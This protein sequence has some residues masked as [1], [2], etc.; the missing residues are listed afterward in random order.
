MST[1]E[2]FD[3]YIRQ[4]DEK[5]Y[6]DAISETTEAFSRL[7]LKPFDWVSF[8]QCLMYGDVQS[9]KTSHVLGIIGHAFDEGFR[10]AL[11]LTSDNTRLVDQTFD[12]VLGAFP[13][14]SVCSGNDERRFRS[15][16]KHHKNDQPVIVVLN[17]NKQVLKKWKQVFDSTSAIHGKPLLIVDDEADA[18]SLNAKVNKG[19]VSAINQS[20]GEIRGFAPSCIYLQVTG[21]PQ[22]NLLQAKIDGWRPDTIISFSPGDK[23]IGGEQLFDVLPNPNVKGFATGES[24]E[25]R[26]FTEA[27]ITYLITAMLLQDAGDR[28]CNMLIHNSRH[29]NDHDT[30]AANVVEIIE[31]FKRGLDTDG[32]REVV[33]NIWNHE[34]QP[35]SSA[36]HSVEDILC[37]LH[38]F[39]RSAKIETRIVNSDN[40]IDDEASLKTG[41]NIVIGGDSLGRGLT[42]PA[43]Q[44]V[45]YS[46]TSRTPQADTL[47][48]HARMFGY[49][50]RLN[51]LRLFMPGDVLKT[52]HEVH[53]GN[54]AIKRQ[55][56]SDADIDEINVD[57][58]V[59]VRPTRPSVLNSD[60]LKVLVG[61]VNYFATDP[62]VKDMEG[63]DSILD[64][65]AAGN[66]DLRV[67]TKAVVS[68]L[69][70]FEADHNDFPVKSF[71]SILKDR[72][73]SDTADQCWL[74]LRRGRKVRQGTGSLLSENDRKACD[75][76]TTVP[77]LTLYRIDQ[78]LGW[79]SAPIW[80]PNIKLQD[81]SLYY[82]SIE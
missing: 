76:I 44:T 51:F 66:D 40:K 32:M 75:A 21:T 63:L 33:S 62:V 61:G 7:V 10:F 15:T 45:Y 2:F 16:V 64:N 50:R 60:Y 3:R 46:R 36:P 12:R 39:L 41:F 82:R 69:S 53:T 78:S 38:Y 5:P 65:F 4:I 34:L 20:L 31:E 1:S 56:R 6:R 77:V 13:T 42:I 43:L 52:F 9:G 49:D 59:A 55:L 47:W 23:Y 74:L 28:A 35:L 19:E 80:V 27:V 26:A 24:A 11:F 8:R 81:G 72:I 17:K 70:H 54:Q 68:I 30:A 14:A 48:Q 37:Q 67:S 71:I 57:L 29:R 18:A 22:A 58:G 25:R 73:E 79:S